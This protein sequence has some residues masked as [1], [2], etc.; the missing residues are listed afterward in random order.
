MGRVGRV[1]KHAWRGASALS[2]IQW[3]WGLLP[4]SAIGVVTGALAIAARLP[5]LVTAVLAF[6][7]ATIAYLLYVGVR[8]D[9]SQRQLALTARIRERSLERKAEIVAGLARGAAAPDVDPFAASGEAGRSGRRDTSLPEALGWAV[10]G[11]WGK[12]F[13]GVATTAAFASGLGIGPDLYQLLARFGAL[14]AGG[15]LTFWGKRDDPGYY[16]EI[17]K[18]YWTTS[19]LSLPDLFGGITTSGDN[20]YRSLMLNKAEVER[21]WPHEG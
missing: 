8:I 15:A 4:A 14:A 21:A 11:E 7:A 19:E 10:H 3:L 6:G 1:F 16:E 17:P 18:A 13:H 12:P 20:P 2:T 5:P 9:L